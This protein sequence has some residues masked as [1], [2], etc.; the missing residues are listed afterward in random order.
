[1]GPSRTMESLDTDVCPPTPSPTAGVLP[2][3]ALHNSAL[4]TRVTPCLHHPAS[5]IPSS[6]PAIPN[7]ASRTTNLNLVLTQPHP[8]PRRRTRAGADHARRVR[9]AVRRCKGLPQLR[10]RRVTTSRAPHLGARVP[11]HHHPPPASP[12]PW[13]PPSAPGRRSSLDSKGTD[14]PRHR[15]P[16]RSLSGPVTVAR[17]PF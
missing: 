13:R 6:C 7:F 11:T 4:S 5:C 8:Y 15:A 16:V 2:S 12:R 3:S 9:R 10:I 1:M 14:A 17:M